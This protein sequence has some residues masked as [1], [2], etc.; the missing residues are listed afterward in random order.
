MVRAALVSLV[1]SGALLVG[2]G[3]A[4]ADSAGLSVTAD[5]GRVDP[6]AY[7]PRT[8]TVSG[9]AT[10]SKRLFI[11]HRAAGGTPC[12][13]SAF[14][15]AG[16]FVDGSFYNVPVNGAFTFQKVLTWREPGTWMVCFWLAST[17]TSVTTPISQMVAV[18]APAASIGASLAPNPPRAG[19]LAQ[20][21]VAGAS[22]ATRRVYAK[23]RPAD[24]TPCATTF[25]ADP[26]GAMISGW[27][28]TG[29]F[30]INANINNPTEGTFTVCL[31]LA[32]ES[33]DALPVAG[34]IAQSF[35][36][37]RARAIVVS[38]TTLLNCRARATLRQ[39][40]VRS[41]VRSVCLRY[42]FRSAPL[43]GERLSLTYVT[44]SHRT[45]KTVAV[46][47]KGGTSQTLATAALPVKAYRHRKGLWRVLLQVDNHQVSNRVF[48]VR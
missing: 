12:A 21:T 35:T 30:S 31:W 9:T 2:A 28:V 34:P 39:V 43:K 19:D 14:T 29:P 5:D 40:K 8:I 44:P 13:S 42:R 6:V 4:R 15:D 26:G 47:S 32:G 16:T 36:V 38:S 46:T 41:K 37:V 48:R 25:D 33:D 17:E 3:I 10:G 1:V 27:S 22:E 20:V 23:L 7:I 45:Y 18:R 24:G 11:K